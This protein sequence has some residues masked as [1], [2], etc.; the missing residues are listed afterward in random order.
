LWP[1]DTAP[2]ATIKVEAVSE[3]PTHSSPENG[4]RQKF[5]ENLSELIQGIE[6]RIA[7]ELEEASAG[8][9]RALSEELNQS[10]RRLRQCASTEEVATWL[11]DSSAPAFCGQAALFEVMGAEVRGVRA[12][13]FEIAEPQAFERFAFQLDHAPALAHAA[14]ERDTVVAIGSPGE[15]SPEI[16]AA[17]RQPPGSKVYL[18]PVAIQDKTVAILYAVSDGRRA[19]GAAALELLT[20]AAASAAQLLA[21]EE[22]AGVRTPTKDAAVTLPEDLPLPAKLI[23]IEGIDMRA[24]VRE[25]APNLEREALAAR[26]RWF[27]REEVA[28]MRLF[29]REALERGRVGRNIYSALKEPIDAARNTYSQDYLAVSTAI[30][31]YLDRELIGLAHDDANLLG[32]EYPGSLV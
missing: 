29:H 26:A 2:G 3:N 12:R 16:L 25:P 10:M 20:H 18:F 30:A 23:A 14:R 7:V 5:S 13:G 8:A 19:V 6:N 4:A 28:R 11:V 21:P 27:A 15:V 22:T 24:H 17:L 31:D 9:R 1:S 32:P